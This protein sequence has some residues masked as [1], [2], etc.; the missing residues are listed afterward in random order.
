MITPLAKRIDNELGPI[1]YS[2]NAGETAPVPTIT[3]AEPTLDAEITEAFNSLWAEWRELEN[4]AGPLARTALS[5]ATVQHRRDFI[6]S[7]KKG[8]G[9]DVGK[10]TDPSARVPARPK[11]EK[12]LF[13]RGRLIDRGGPAIFEQAVNQNVQ[14][15]KTIG[16][17][18]LDKVESVIWEGVRSGSDGWSL[19]KEIMNINGQNYNRAKVIARDQLQ[20]YNSALSMSR[21]QSIG[22]EGYIWRTSLDDRVRDNPDDDHKSKEGVRFDWNNP[23]P[24]TGHP[25]EDIQCRCTAEPD[26]SNLVAWGPAVRL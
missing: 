26:L 10:I 16:P 8:A 18:Y 1:L 23:P 11:I 6:T 19:K 3:D 4:M 12:E 21:Q 9:I 20:K 17:Q 15:I 24:D 25:G 13:S 22:I 5:N 14:L 2:L 7:F